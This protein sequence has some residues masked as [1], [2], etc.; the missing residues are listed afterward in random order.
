MKK[1]YMSLYTFQVKQDRYLLGVKKISKR[2]KR[3]TNL[4]SG[5]GFVYIVFF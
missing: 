1:T 2:Q 5:E 3:N 4:V